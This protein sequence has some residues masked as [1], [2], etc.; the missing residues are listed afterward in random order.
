MN[1]PVL[2]IETPPEE[3]K[4]NLSLTD[5][6]FAWICLISAYLFCRVSPIHQSPLGGFVL[7]FSLYIIT[8]VFL[9][10]KGARFTPMAVISALSAILLCL[11]LILSDNPVIHFFSYTYALV[12]WLYYA[13]AAFG[14]SLK[15][16]FSDLV[17]IDY[18][19]ALFVLPFTKLG[20]LFAAVFSNKK[21]SKAFRRLIIGIGIA[22]IPTVIVLALLSYDAS[23]NKL[24]DKIF[25]FEFADLW[26]H[27]VSIGLAF[28]LSAFGYGLFV[29]AHD[30]SYSD[31][32]TAEGCKK[33]SEVIK[34]A[35]LLTVSAA[36]LPILGLYIIF[37]V[38]QWKYYISGFTGVL[39]EGFVYSEYAREGFFQL[40]A[41]SVINLIIIALVSSF[42][43]RNTKAKSVVTKVICVL[44]SLSSLVL[45]S[46][47]IAKL[48]MYIG[49]YGL[50]PLRVY[51]AWFECVL[52]VI[53][54]L[55]ILK[56]F[57]P[58]LNIVISSLAVLVICFSVL[59]IG[60]IDGFIADYN[61]DRYLEESLDN[62]DTE[63]LFDLGD[64]AVPALIR[65][66]KETKGR[67]RQ[68]NI[69]ANDILNR[70]AN[71][72][73]DN[74]KDENIFSYTLP[75]YRARALI[76]DRLDMKRENKV[77]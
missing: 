36:T 16:G 23:F 53:F 20:A 72:I 17:A 61:V 55:I 11:G 15:K 57:V 51:A 9:A 54:L 12:T 63:I 48:S 19:K 60:N 3:E 6:L 50:T 44:Y 52:A 28:P 35:P 67:D 26:S 2:I 64:S 1:E 39:P 62:V 38:S 8:T 74:E 14:N 65:L 7:I 34:F 10:L 73:V 71:S 30:K 76:K 70:I 43:K 69:H 56:Q 47:A 37:F 24:I 5:T 77:D 25:D 21:G 45:I 46:T 18:F 32:I 22:I 49:I 75:D 33:A 4:N 13:Y 31:K 68:V 27:L 29:S 41:V 42:S 40:C 66:E 58:K 59:C